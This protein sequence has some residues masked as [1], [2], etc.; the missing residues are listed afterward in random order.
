MINLMK[1]DLYR[2]F[3]GIG[4][5]IAIAMVIIMSSVSIAMKEAGYIGNASVEN[6]NATAVKTE[7]GSYEYSIEIDENTTETADKKELVRSIYAAN[8][9]LY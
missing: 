6:Y 4:I 7:E 2:I 3:K 8:T 1:A 5:Y 9:N